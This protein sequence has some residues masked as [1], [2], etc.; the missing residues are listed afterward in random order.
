MLDKQKMGLWLTK[1]YDSLISPINIKKIRS[2]RKKNDNLNQE[3][4]TEL[5]RLTGQMM[6]VSTQTWLDVAFDVSDE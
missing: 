1:I 4:K 6:W 5:K 2:L 3:E